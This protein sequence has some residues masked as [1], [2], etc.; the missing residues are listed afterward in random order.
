MIMQFL[1]FVPGLN[2]LLLCTLLLASLYPIQHRV[3]H[4]KIIW[5][6][7]HYLLIKI[8]NCYF[9]VQPSWLSLGRSFTEY[10][11]G[12][13]PNPLMYVRGSWLGLFSSDTG[14]NWKFWI[15][16]VT[17]KKSLFLAS[18]SPTH[19][20]LL[21]PNGSNL[22]IKCLSNINNWFRLIYIKDIISQVCILGT[23][24]MLTH[25]NVY[26]L[27]FRLNVVSM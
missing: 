17:I 20:R 2:L 3:K 14:R 24:I 10:S 22:R 27:E 9:N 16:D 4:L 19:T 5:P 26:S 23:I 18:A 21:A 6:E 15:S 7:A 25:F 1:F 12:I 8:H 11:C 13:T